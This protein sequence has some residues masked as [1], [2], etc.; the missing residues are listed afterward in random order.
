VPRGY[1]CQPQLAITRQAEALGIDVLPPADLTRTLDAL[2]PRFAATT[3]GDPGYGQLAATADPGLRGG[4]SDGGEMGAFHGLQQPQR[5]TQL[6]ELIDEYS[7][8]GLD[9][10]IF[11]VD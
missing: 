9:V 2:R 1:R 8:F 6:R 5:E 10:G 7:R 4:A 11:F 3:Y